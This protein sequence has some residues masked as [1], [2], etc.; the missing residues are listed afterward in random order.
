MEEVQTQ[1]SAGN[2]KLE[3]V[4]T[5]VI[6][7]I[8]QTQVHKDS[9]PQRKREAS[10]RRIAPVPKNSPSKCF[11]EEEIGWRLPFSPHTVQRDM[12][13]TLLAAARS[14]SNAIIDSPTGTGK[15]LA[16]LCGGL[17]YHE[18]LRYMT[19]R[20]RGDMNRGQR[21]AKSP[22]HLGITILGTKNKGT[23]PQTGKD[24]NGDANE[25]VEKPAKESVTRRVPP[26]FYCSRTHSQLKQVIAEFGNLTKRSSQ[27]MNVLASR[28]R[29]CINERVRTGLQNTSNNL[30]EMCDKAVV[31]HQCDAYE[32]Y[33]DLTEHMSMVPH[34]WQIEDLVENG[35]GMESCPYYAARDLIYNAYINFCPYNYIL[36]PIIRHE[37]KIEGVLKDA[38]IILDEAHNIDDICRNTLEWQWAEKDLETT[39]EEMQPYIDGQAVL[40]SKQSLTE[41]TEGCDEM[42]ALVQLYAQELLQIFTI[43]QSRDGAPQIMYANEVEQKLPLVKV[44]RENKG[45]RAMFAA[46]LRAFMDFGVTFN[47][48]DA[49][50]QSIHT[51]KQILI[52]M[53]LFLYRKASFSMGID[54][55][56]RTI[57]VY[58]ADSSLAFKLLEQDVRCVILASGTLP[59]TDFISKELG[60]PFK[61][62]T[63]C[64]HVVDVKEAIFGRIIT[65]FGRC[66][67]A[68]MYKNEFID[69]LGQFLLRSVESTAHGRLCFFPS[70]KCMHVYWDRWSFTGIRNKLQGL[71]VRIF[72]EP[73]NSKDFGD[74]FR[75]YATASKRTKGA[76]LLAVYRGKAAEGID[77]KDHMA[78]LI[79]C[80][81]VPYKSAAEARTIIKKKYNTECSTLSGDMWYRTDAVTAVNQAIGRCI[82][83]Q[84]DYGVLLLIDDRW[85]R[86][87]FGMLPKWLRPTIQ[88]CEASDKLFDSMRTFL[89]DK[90]YKP[91]KVKNE[92]EY[93]KVE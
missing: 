85:K 70:Y 79:V 67:Y 13:T 3:I 71:G 88:P 16:L 24:R 66:L 59:H 64:G 40:Y 93:I 2:E 6:D 25:P 68:N 72:Q 69:G 58:C 39:V 34:E 10:G 74:V 91:S 83:H 49:K 82:R 50:T 55:K 89:H 60:A 37:T 15:T 23:G 47:A 36:D 27:K 33:K 45:R 4:N 9:S 7:L 84:S 19:F 11:D 61:E 81:G 26:I 87:L 31:L 51:V 62:E 77:F 28:D 21:E 76:L 38:V 57:D 12:I 1:K 90:M 5:E 42:A 30:G 18:E 8:D 20:D 56:Q 46:A 48:L 86:E 78:R 43:A 22:S 73:R 17:K 65:N 92:V 35:K 52:F 14:G 80:I 63:R 44:L 29:Y 32:N 75:H 41:R 53:N 54:L